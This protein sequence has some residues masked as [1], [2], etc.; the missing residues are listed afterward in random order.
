MEE[1]GHWITRLLG[2]LDLD[3]TNFLGGPNL[4]NSPQAYLLPTK[5]EVGGRGGC[6]ISTPHL[7]KKRAGLGYTSF[8]NLNLFSRVSNALLRIQT[9][10]PLNTFIV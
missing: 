6:V 4:L 2:L 8:W 5:V 10:K 3:C 1:M 9:N 7:E